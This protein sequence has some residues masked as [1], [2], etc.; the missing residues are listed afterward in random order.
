MEAS[1]SDLV[2]WAD[3]PALSSDRLQKVYDWQIAEWSTF[4]NA[5]L[6]AAFGVLTSVL[7]EAFKETLKL[8]EV[9]P[10]VGLAS[11][12]CASIYAFCRY[13]VSLL[14]REFVALYTILLCIK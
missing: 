10:M 12:A 1:V 8:P 4:G 14:R 3:D 9:L 7:I 5:A 11:L 2:V 6:T 13:R